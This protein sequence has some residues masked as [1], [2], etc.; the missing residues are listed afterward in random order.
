MP[1]S[2]I[3]LIGAVLFERNGKW[4]T[5]SRCMMAEAFVRIDKEEIGP[6]LSMIV[7]AA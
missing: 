1:L 4:Q 6:I 5:A 2:I 3:R 7:K